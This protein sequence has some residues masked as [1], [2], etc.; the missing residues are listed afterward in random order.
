MSQN[1]ES[2]R[3]STPQD[4]SRRLWDVFSRQV[5]DLG[6]RIAVSATDT[7]ISFADLFDA[8]EK[9]SESL[10]NTGVCAGA[11]VGLSV[12]NR[13][14]FIVAYLALCRL[15]A[16]VALISPKYNDAELLP[17]LG[18][19][20]PG[21][22]ITADDA[23]SERLSAAT[24]KTYHS[25][26]LGTSFKVFIADSGT[27]REESADQW[28]MPAMIKC[29]SGSTGIPKGIAVSAENV[30]AE[31]SNV[32]R[33]HMITGDDRILVPVPLSHS[34]GFDLAVLPMLYAG[35][36]LIL[37]EHFIP[38]QI[39][40]DLQDNQISIFLGVPSIYRVL[41]ET[42]FPAPPDLSRVRYLLSCT[43][44]L[45]P[46]SI[47][48]FH[49]TFGVAICQHYGSSE[50]GAA[51]THIPAEVL[52]RP[53]SVGRAINGVEIT[54]VD[55][56]GRPVPN[57][58]TGEVVIS[59]PAVAQGYILG[60]ADDPCPLANGAYR[61]GDLGY[62]DDDGFLFLLGRKDRLMNVGGFKVAPEE[63]VFVLESHPA[64]R[65]AAVIGAKDH[66][67]EEVVY[68]AV[69][70]KIPAEENEL[71]RHCRNRLAEYKVPRRIDIRREL[72]RLPSGKIQLRVED[73]AW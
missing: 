2:A 54:I 4:V 21:Y 1:N 23:S 5:R 57:G 53:Q 56:E 36:R 44:P 9:L 16:T 40:H 29:T 59:G 70:L 60:G 7:D 30:L 64:V 15:S 67:G 17:I 37:R 27:R 48:V 26:Q 31:A 68:A 14:E 25:K 58:S 13:P 34:Y 22:L 72:P 62:L 52:L 49:R 55:D 3:S 38:R 51:A 45:S 20:Q 63:V 50:T 66:S 65:E 28:P 10:K 19:I 71:L 8:A 35:A 39:I 11:I 33:A 43:A 24:E 46:D 12:P 69:I 32:V 73:I 18:G 42:R 61:T 6:D 47:S 41:T